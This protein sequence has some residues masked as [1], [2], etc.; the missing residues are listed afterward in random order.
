MVP[1]WRIFGDVL[2][3][4][5]SENRVQHISDLH[6]KF[7]LRPHHIWKYGRMQSATA[8]NRRGKKEEEDDEETT[9]QKYNG[10]PYS[11]E[12]L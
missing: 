6:S 5:F 9:E 8:E 11:T 2:R 10:L 4:V 1:R 12:R 7:E 3:P